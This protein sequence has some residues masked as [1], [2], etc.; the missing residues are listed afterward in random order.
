[1]GRRNLPTHWFLHGR[2]LPCARAGNDLYPSGTHRRGYSTATFSST[3][4]GTNANGNWNLYVVD[5]VGG[6]TGSIAG[7]WSI[8]FVTG[9]TCPSATPSPS[10]TATAVASRPARA[11]RRK[12]FRERFSIALRDK[13]LHQRWSHHHSGDE[14]GVAT[15]APAAPYPSTINVAGMGGTISKVTVRLNNI[16]HTFPRRHRRCRR[17]VRGD[18]PPF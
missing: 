13:Y 7:G 1:M 3:F 14:T 2:F 11:L 5:F 9:A 6:D 10:V 16:A 18:R 4:G 8:T 15:G 12:S 17:S